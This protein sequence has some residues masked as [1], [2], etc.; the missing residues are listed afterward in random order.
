M[1]TPAPVITEYAGETL[2]GRD[3]EILLL[4]FGQYAQD[5]WR[6]DAELIAV[7]ILN[8]T[9][10]EEMPAT[11]PWQTLYQAAEIQPQKA[12]DSIYEALNQWQG[13][14]QTAIYS[15]LSLVIQKT[16]ARYHAMK[17]GAQANPQKQKRLATPL[18][19]SPD[20]VL[21]RAIENELIPDKRPVVIRMG[22]IEA[23]LVDWLAKHGKFVKSDEGAYYLYRDGHIL[24][25]MDTER[26]EAFLHTLTGVNP[27]SSAFGVITSAAKTAASNAA[28]SA[29][30]VKFA[31]YDRDTR[32]LRISRFDGT[33]Y[34]LDGDEIKTETNGEGPALFYDFPTWQPY[35]PDPVDA[36][37][38]AE[39]A[40]V[41]FWK[42]RPNL[43]GWIFQVW[44]QT[45]FFTE[46][47]PTRPIM[48][49]L[50]EKGSGKSM[51]LRML[52][53]LL[54]GQFADISGVPEKPDA[55]TVAA[56]YYHLYVMDN[57]DTLEPW[58]RDK[59]ARI[60][61]GATDEYRKL[62]TSKE[63]GI[64]RYR[65]WL[66]ITART[67]DTLRRD[68]LAD[69]VVILPLK[70][71]PDDQRGRE[72]DFTEWVER[73][74]NGFWFDLLN[75]LN[76]IVAELRAGAIPQAS[77]LRMADWE[78]L[79]RLIS[80]IY[81]NE[82]IWDEIVAEIKGE[83][84]GFLAEGEVIVEAIEAWLTL[85]G[86]LN[87]W[88]TARELYNEAQ[89]A[90]FGNN[91]PDTDWPRSVKSFGWRLKNTADYLRERF[92]MKV[93]DDKHY[94]ASKYCFSHL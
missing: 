21:K 19:E 22:N 84:R 79:G 43:Y 3:A 42:D 10:P 2:P 6:Q 73:N 17:L 63:M 35:Q 55:L 38:L 31:H 23:M 14:L 78:V 81:N 25:D 15:Y 37:F 80:R 87:R 53:K 90:L 58:M 12:A 59:L 60:S 85:P 26:W 68:D 5:A 40:Q 7:A 27:S 24:Y 64:I 91:K 71:I 76:R 8:D 13:E 88:I 75:R 67:P 57:M 77:P 89:Y 74:R 33:V 62:F 18:I 39:I 29:Q 48:V 9:L 92:G 4:E 11:E 83:Q 69:R 32:T 30:V 1:T 72:L 20:P 28:K 34:V 45:L 16:A 49:F 51:A 61:T 54:F 70:R 86:N 65:T 66:A 56:H 82:K 50:G 44:I 41:P 52:M 47:C 36:D 94:G 46:L 93:V